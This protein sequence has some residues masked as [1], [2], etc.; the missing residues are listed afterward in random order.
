MTGGTECG[1]VWST[2]GSAAAE[3][4]GAGSAAAGNRTVK[5]DNLTLLRQYHET[6]DPRRQ[7]A[8]LAQIVDAN[9]GL[10]RAVAN[11]YTDRIRHHSGIEMEDLYQIGTIGMI[12]A[13]RSFDFSYETTFSTY[14]VPLIVGEIRRCLRDDGMVKV[15]RDVKRR[16]YL[17]WQ[18]K[19][20]F[21]QRQGREP[22]TR[23]LAEASGEDETLL[24][25][26]MDAAGPVASLTEPLGGESDDE[27]FT[28]EGVLAD[29][30]DAIER[31]TDR[32][33]LISAVEKLSERDRMILRLRYEK[34]LSQQQT[35][36]ILGL[37][38][39]KISRTEKKIFAFLREQMG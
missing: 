16:G 12:K 8:L 6:D 1:T 18:A 4:V 38:Q 37:S 7:E 33:T 31:L 21:Y 25:F 13:V 19:E 11:R 22:T 15:S 20:A 10:V 9:F 26:L 17:V 29:E 3:S 32:L 36:A 39:V 2:A 23:E 30:D 14:A 28:L 5:E 35:A 27:G 24:V 34:S